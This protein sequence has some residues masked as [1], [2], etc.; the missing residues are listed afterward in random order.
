MRARR[1]LFWLAAAAVVGGLS[2]GVAVAGKPVG[3][4]GV[5][6]GTVYFWRFGNQN[7][8]WTITGY[9][10][11]SDFPVKGPMKGSLSGGGDAFATKIDAS[12]TS[13]V[14]SVYL[15]GS[16]TE[17]GRG[18]TVDGSGRAFVVGT[19]YSTDYPT[20]K[21][22]QGSNGGTTDAFVSVLNASGDAFVY[23]TYLGGS[24][25]DRVTGGT[26]G[27][28][29]AGQAIALDGNGAAIVVGDTRSTDFPTQA[30]FQ[31]T[32]AGGTYDA[33]VFRL[34][35]DGGSSGSGPAAPT[36][37]VATVSPGNP[38]LLSWTDNSDNETGFDVERRTDVTDFQ[39]EASTRANATVYEDYA[40]VPNTIY[41]YRVRAVNGAGASD[42][43][44]EASVTASAIVPAP[45]APSDLVVVVATRDSVE[46]SWIDQS[47]TE[48]GFQVKRRTGDGEYENVAM[49]GEG[50]V[51][52]VESGLPPD[53]E[54]VYGV[55]A[56]GASRF[57][58]YAEVAAATLPT[59]SVTTVAGDLKD[60]AKFG[61]DSLKV[62]ASYGFIAGE[63]D[64]AADLVA[65]GFTIRVGPE[66]APLAFR[67]LPADEGWKVRGTKATWKSPKESSRKFKVQ[68]DSE[69]RLVK[70]SVTGMEFTVPPA[71]PMRVSI[72]VGN[73][74]GTTRGDWEETKPGAFRLR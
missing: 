24:G 22:V 64:G 26:D 60:T 32:H 63:S 50:A 27:A 23:S 40:T 61:K 2:A 9:T 14:Y 52:F 71:N 34:S 57:S 67:I 55:R 58:A 73:D 16:G 21:P 35:G 66:A 38:I 8:M 62:T 69:R 11:S 31:A 20:Q 15:G 4:G 42:Y 68:V 53:T 74:A 49:T 45:K 48:I 54:Y 37:L 56:V 28:S 51:S 46:L 10:G 7:R 30:P 18:I 6:T 13:L 65:E 1:V 41:T 44:N 39:R 70:F 43:S 12:G 33:F 17:I 47:T 36:G 5:D 29:K 72:V 19:T 25:G 59:L 3:G